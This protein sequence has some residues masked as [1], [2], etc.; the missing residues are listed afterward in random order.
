MRRLRR[1]LEAARAEALRWREDCDQMN[2]TL[3]LL[4]DRKDLYLSSPDDRKS[5]GTPY[6][7]GASQSVSSSDAAITPLP[8]YERERPVVAS[9]PASRRGGTHPEVGSP[10]DVK[11]LD[12]SPPQP[13]SDSMQQRSQY[14]GSEGMSIYP[15][16]KTKPPVLSKAYGPPYFSLATEAVDNA[17][18][19]W[20]F[21]EVAPS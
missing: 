10:L 15:D 18:T 3:R 12:V 5:L 1:D 2:R 7:T 19:S 20:R 8:R 6:L 11:H 16:F 14:L 17:G 21:P 13:E 4:D 9:A